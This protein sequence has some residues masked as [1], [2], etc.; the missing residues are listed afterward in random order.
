M[1]WLHIDYILRATSVTGSLANLLRYMLMFFIR[2]HM[3]DQLLWLQVL[4]AN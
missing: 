2:V 3:N 1:N 4:E